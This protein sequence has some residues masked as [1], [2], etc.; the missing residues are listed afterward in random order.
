MRKPEVQ[1]RSKKRVREVKSGQ[2]EKERMEK[3]PMNLP[4]RICKL[5]VLFQR[6]VIKLTLKSLP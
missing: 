3:Q 1:V 6:P 4:K 5:K 2:P